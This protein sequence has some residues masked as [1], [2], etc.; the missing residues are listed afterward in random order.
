[1][2]IGLICPSNMLYMPYVD[3]YTKIL[4]ENNANY[5]IINWDRFGIEE[6]SEFTYRDDEV[7]HQRNFF[8]YYK[9][10]RFII[11]KLHKERFDKLIVFGLQL[12]FFLKRFLLEKYNGRYIIDIRDYNKIIKFS[13]FDKLIEKSIF[14]VISSQGYKEWLPKTNKYVINHNTNIKSVDKLKPI[15]LKNNYEKINIAYIGAIRDYDINI[16][17]IKSLSNNEKIDLFYH[18]EGNINNDIIRFLKENDISNVMFTGRYRKESELELYEQSDI[19][20]VLRFNDSINNKTALPNRLYNATIYGKPMI[21]FKG[22]YLAKIIQDYN[23][24][25][26]IES[27]DGIGFKIEN[28]LKK[29]DL[30]QYENLRSK[31]IT[32]VIEENHIF[33]TKLSKF[34]R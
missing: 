28:Y 6:I 32:K 23:L 21:A 20:N 12:S 11:K 5:T 7:G 30:I 15:V 34:A 9:Y 22:T 24:G 2:K 8:D 17:L 18:G 33:I 29:F 14:T 27:F 31:F 10:Y 25:L 1:M 16:K 3:N 4:K 19:I 26:V 13:N